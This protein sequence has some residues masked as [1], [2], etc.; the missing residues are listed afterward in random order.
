MNLTYVEVMD[1][2]RINEA[3]RWS[4]NLKCIANA[5]LDDCDKI[6]SCNSK[7]DRQSD[8]VQNDEYSLP[9]EQCKRC[10]CVL[11]HHAL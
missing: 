10:N 5:L 7:F 8:I 4:E 9:F 1:T 2:E 3:I 6:T 11:V